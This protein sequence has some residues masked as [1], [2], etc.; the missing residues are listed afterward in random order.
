MQVLLPLL[1]H[2]RRR[3]QKVLVFSRSTRLLDILEA[4]LF[5]QGLSPQML[6]L[7]GTTPPGNRQRLVDEFNTSVARS[8]FLIST[9]AGGVGLNLTSASVVVI[10]DPDWNPFSDLQA[11]DR[12]FRIGQTRVVEVYRLLGAGTIEEQ[13][14]V[15]Q[16]WK[17]QLARSAIDG[18]RSA[19]RIDD[20]SFGLGSL[21]EL[22]E[23]SMLPSLMAEAF[24]CAHGQVPTAE[25]LEGGVRVF[26]DLRRPGQDAGLGLAELCKDNDHSEA[27]AVAAPHAGLD[28]ADATSATQAL[29]LLHG[30]MDQVDHAKVI[31]EDTQENMLLDGLPQA[32]AEMT[33]PA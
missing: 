26:R 14:Y 7:D 9:R 15:R 27:T 4:C 33:E 31:R 18:T 22:H 20:S 30:M 19:R 13:I 29:D 3:G 1:R 17:Q 16:I 21:F 32:D 25:A 6:R 2:W 24:Q 10:F 11:Q 28:Q 8:V 5:Q 23:T 12:S